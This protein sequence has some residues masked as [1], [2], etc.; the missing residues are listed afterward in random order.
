MKMKKIIENVKCILLLDT[1][2]F[3]IIYVLGIIFSD[4][5]EFEF[6]FLIAVISV[7]CFDGYLLI[8]SIK[9]PKFIVKLWNFV[10]AVAFY[11]LIIYFICIN[12]IPMELPKVYGNIARIAFAVIGLHFTNEFLNEFLEYNIPKS[13]RHPTHEGENVR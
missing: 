8:A 13:A 5:G 1:V 12:L 3:C 7:I 6:P 10:G 4:R 11:S 2:I 9:I